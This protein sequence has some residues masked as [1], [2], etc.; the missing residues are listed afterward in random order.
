LKILQAL[1]RKFRLDDD[2]NLSD[3]VKTCPTNYTGADFYA[4]AS[5][6]LSIALKRRANEISE[7]V[8]LSQKESLYYESP[9]TLTKYLQSLTDKEL[10]VYVSMSDFMK[11]REGIVA[12]VSEEEHNKYKRL[13]DEYSP[14]NTNV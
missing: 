6:A 3:I 2:V 8:E 7:Y 14:S 9:T 10:H 5:N 4:L 1:V 13:R 11:A 12:S